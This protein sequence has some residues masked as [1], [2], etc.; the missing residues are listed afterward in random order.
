VLVVQQVATLM[1]EG[2]DGGSGSER[3]GGLRQAQAVKDSESP[4][5]GVRAQEEGRRA[6]ATQEQL[7]QTA[8][9]RCRGEQGAAARLFRLGCFRLFGLLQRAGQRAPSH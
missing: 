4:V 1:G 7:R 5:R 9:S 3:I 6:K 8:Y 2:T